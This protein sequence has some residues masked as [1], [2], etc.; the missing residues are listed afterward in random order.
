MIDLGAII[1][2]EL[3]SPQGRDLQER[4]LEAMLMMERHRG[5]PVDVT[6]S[7]NVGDADVG[8][9]VI[10]SL[11]DALEKFIRA[12]PGHRDVGSAVW[13]LGKLREERYSA[14]FATIAEENS[15]YCDWARDQALCALADM[16]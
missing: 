16:V 6:V 8:E 2:R 1:I 15:G 4:M 10:K 14:L 5:I 3:D 11:A 7:P 9:L 12:F 13:A